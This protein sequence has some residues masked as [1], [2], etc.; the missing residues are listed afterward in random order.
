VVDE[1]GPDDPGEFHRWALRR[2]MELAN[3]PLVDTPVVDT[4]VH[5][6]NELDDMRRDIFEDRY[7]FDA[8]RKDFLGLAA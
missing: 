7:G 1:I 4:R 6:E 2:A 5:R 8:R 3:T